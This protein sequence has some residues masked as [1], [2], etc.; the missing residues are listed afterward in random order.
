MTQNQLQELKEALTYTIQEKV[1]GKIDKLT[2]EVKS[3]HHRLDA[4]DLAIAPAI[5]TIHTI[6]SGVNFTKWIWPF[7]LIIGVIILWIQQ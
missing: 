5:E 4:Q 2:E 1:N 3:I 6:R 7:F